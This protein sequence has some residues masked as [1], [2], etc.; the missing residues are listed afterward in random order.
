M[1]A[2]LSA[3]WPSL[4]QRIVAVHGHENKENGPAENCDFLDYRCPNCINGECRSLMAGLDRHK[5]RGKRGKG[6]LTRTYPIR[7]LMQLVHRCLRKSKSSTCRARAASTPARAVRDPAQHWRYRAG[8]GHYD[9]GTRA[10]VA[11]GGVGHGLCGTHGA[12][13]AVGTPILTGARLGSI[14]VGP[15]G[16]QRGRDQRAGAVALHPE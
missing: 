1:R 9:P 16:G 14:P 3:A 7:G 15:G 4:A 5:L 8:G 12:A 6:A 11:H 10:A 2:A 13:L